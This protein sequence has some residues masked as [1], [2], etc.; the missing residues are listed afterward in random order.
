MWAQA[1]ISLDRKR[2]LLHFHADHTLSTSR[3][4]AVDAVGA[5]PAGDAGLERLRHKLGPLNLD[6]LI[7]SGKLRASK[8]GRARRVLILI[9]DIEA[10]LAAHVIA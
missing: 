10:M 5:T 6:G 3:V 7:S 9:A 4:S 1:S 8:L 2:W